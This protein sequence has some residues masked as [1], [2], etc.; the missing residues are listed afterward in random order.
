MFKQGHVPA[1]TTHQL[2]G[3]AAGIVLVVFAIPYHAYASMGSGA[4]VYVETCAVCHGMGGEGGMPGVPDLSENKNLFAEQEEALLS[5]MKEG[6]STPSS[7]MNM[8]P[9]GGNPKLSDQQI[10]DA[11]RYLRSVISD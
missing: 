3:S 8:P 10:I 2:F 4:Q 7:P 11:L 5:R 6:I 1:L 9:Y